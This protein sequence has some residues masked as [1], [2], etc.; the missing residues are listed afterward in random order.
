MTIRYRLTRASGAAQDLIARVLTDAG[1]AL[2][3][4]PA[5]DSH[6]PGAA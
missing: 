5:N 2:G 4:R 6:W 3:M 1:L